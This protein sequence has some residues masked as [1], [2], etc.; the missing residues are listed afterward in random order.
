MSLIIF[1]GVLR[2]CMPVLNLTPT[3]YQ[4]WVLHIRHLVRNPCPLKAYTPICRLKAE[5]SQLPTAPVPQMRDKVVVTASIGRAENPERVID[6]STKPKSTARKLPDMRN[7][8][9]ACHKAK[10]AKPE[11]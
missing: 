4:R 3:P 1:W 11:C 6:S 10:R 5:E 9:V 2:E 7:L 8:S